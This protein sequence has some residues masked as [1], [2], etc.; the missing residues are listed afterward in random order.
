[1]GMRATTATR[2]GAGAGA[3][4]WLMF[5]LL[6]VLVLV[7]EANSFGAW[8]WRGS[9]CARSLGGSRCQQAY[10]SSASSSSRLWSSSTPSQPFPPSE[11]WKTVNE[12][13]VYV[14]NLYEALGVQ[15]NSTT[16]EIKE[17]YKAL[18]FQN[19]P[20]R[21]GSVAA[22]YLFRNAS[23]AYQTLG[24][25]PKLRAEYD[26][27]YL[28]RMYL[29]VLE[30]VGTEVLRPLA[31]DVAVPLINFTARALGS[32]LKPLVD[33]S[34]S[35]TS[36]V[37]EVWSASGEPPPAPPSLPVS[38]AAGLEAGDQTA[39]APVS[40]TADVAAS[41]PVSA[42]QTGTGG[43]GEALR[44]LARMQRVGE[45]FEAKNY[46]AQREQTLDQ[47]AITSE[48][49]LATT[50]QLAQAQEA[51]AAMVKAVDNLETLQGVVGA[52]RELALAA[53]AASKQALDT[54]TAEE[55]RVRGQCDVGLEYLSSTTREKAAVSAAVARARADVA[56]LE[57]ELAEARTRV[58]VLSEQEQSMETSL[59]QMGASSALL[60]TQL[61]AAAKEKQQA[62]LQYTADQQTRATLDAEE[63]TVRSDLTKLQ[64][65]LAR[66]G[67]NRATLERRLV[68]L[69]KKEKA[70]SDVLLRIDR[71]RAAAI[72]AKRQREIVAAQK[73]KEEK[74]KE[75]EALRRAQDE[76]LAKV[77]EDEDR[78]K[79][80]Q[81]R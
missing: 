79:A 30:D 39:A 59:E 3:G 67:L 44:F 65:D 28:S 6:L 77:A 2:A 19:H 25:D 36:A 72:E 42:S 27:K 32:F 23:H 21:N 11:E 73:L 70:L 13:T 14:E 50:A 51:E 46:E 76:L 38:A 48:R 52:R 81:G 55:A 66:Q 10:S 49:L 43:G 47:T 33:S 60:S 9:S 34:I 7:P 24:R 41:T 16:E 68:Q 78:I 22:L 63:A 74:M 40:G 53:E 31:M 69:G 64:E 15:P 62:T 57:Q 61:E 8:L 80:L 75:L 54:A 1:M 18:V 29:S 45:L 17:A 20:D 12:P 26:S 35:K 4:A 56:R 37:F 71:D 58:Q 5:V